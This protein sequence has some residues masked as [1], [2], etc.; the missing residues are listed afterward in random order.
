MAEVVAYDRELTE[1]ERWD[2]QSYLGSKWG[3]DIAREPDFKLDFSRSGSAEKAAC[4][5]DLAKAQ[6]LVDE[7][8][9][10]IKK[11]DIKQLAGNKKPADV[12]TLIIDGCN[13]LFK[14]PMNPVVAKTLN[15]SKQE[16]PFI[17]ASFKDPTG[18]LTTG[19]GFLTLTN[20]DF[21]K[22]IGDFSEF[23]KD[24]I[25]E[26]TIEF[27]MPYLEL[28]GFLP[29][30]AK[31]ASGSAEGLMTWVHAMTAYHRANT[32]SGYTP[33]DFSGSGSYL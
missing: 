30:V 27:M 8:L 31:N 19:P 23:G 12:I 33:H 15:I 25:N 3:I 18:N 17:Q 9:S 26:E 14:R 20:P 1:E 29:S 4:E 2:V 24:K 32:G 16:V 10:G 21:L 5:K 28:E 7:A 6:R 22:W 13:I 11:K